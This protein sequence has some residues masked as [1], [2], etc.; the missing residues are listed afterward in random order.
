MTSDVTLKG[1]EDWLET[2]LEAALT[3]NASD[4]HIEPRENNLLIRFRVD[5][6]L[7]LFE[8][9]PFEI[10][11]IIVS[12][13][14]VLAEL[15]I[16][17]RRFPQDG[18]IQFPLKDKVYSLRISTIPTELGETLVLRIL[19]REEML[20]KI[21][22][23]GLDNEQVELITQLM[24][25]ANGLILTTGPAGSGKSSLMYSFLNIL[26]TLERN[27]VTVEDP[28]ELNM[29]HINQSQVNEKVGLGYTVLLRS[30]LRQDPDVIMIGEI[31][32]KET[33]Q[34]TMQ[35]ALSGALVL[36]TFHSFDVPALV[37]RLTDFGVTRSVVAQAIRG[38][39]STRLLRKICTS[40]SQPAELTATERK[41]LGNAYS[42]YQ[43]KRGAGCELCG[44][45]GYSG[46]IGVHEIVPFDYEIKSFIIDNNPLLSFYELIYKKK[47]KSLKYVAIQRAVDG[48]T[49]VDEVIRKI[50]FEF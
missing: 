12:R 9:L 5:G 19:N 13:L 21:E 26:N 11:D 32:D 20:K 29:P 44:K 7:K 40:C 41:F 18:H 45:T 28:V 38:V 24:L 23:T 10:H 48:I 6:S 22:V 25:S 17:N 8:N 3:Q 1:G 47:V 39:I 30:I 49:T 4:I 50:G 27:I 2:I 35:A 46:R 34:I 33:L 43:F 14:K 42:G 16:T 37:V 15:D 31:R 36:S